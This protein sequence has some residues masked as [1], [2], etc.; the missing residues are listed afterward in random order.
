M[1]IKTALFFLSLLCFLA[2]MPARAFAYT[3]P[4]YTAGGDLTQWYKDLQAYIQE[5]INT[6][7]LPTPTPSASANPTVAP[8]STPR[9]STSPTATPT[10]TP[11]PSPQVDKLSYIMGQIN[12]YRSSRGLSS[13]KTD[14]YTCSFA[15]IRAKEITIG[16]NHDGFTKRVN[17]GTLPYPGYRIVTENLAMTSDYRNVVNMWINSPGHAENMRK[18]TP[19]VCVAWSGNYYAYEGWKP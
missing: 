19:Y 5:K 6:S 10:S 14:S 3:L 16:F 8:S 13:V 12:K 2:I 17:S 4:T 7:T 9:P 15:Q 18:D 11:T 1:N